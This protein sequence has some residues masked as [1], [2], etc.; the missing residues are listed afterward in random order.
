MPKLPDHII[1][2]VTTNGY[3]TPANYV[4]NNMTFNTPL[5]FTQFI[6]IAAAPTIYTEAHY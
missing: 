5:L 1:S 2:L 4:H 3:R 6:P